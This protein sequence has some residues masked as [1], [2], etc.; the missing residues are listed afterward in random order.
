MQML[1]AVNSKSLTVKCVA[2]ESHV[3]KTVKLLKATFFKNESI[4]QGSRKHKATSHF[5][6]P[7]T[8]AQRGIFLLSHVCLWHFWDCKEH[9][10]GIEKQRV[11]TL[12]SLFYLKLVTSFFLHYSGWQCRSLYVTWIKTCRMLHMIPDARTMY[13]PHNMSVSLITL[14]Q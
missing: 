5:L 10:F 13:F 7:K 1:H 9:Y 12:L 6:L 14:F 8:L 2:I 11:L 4:N 3:T